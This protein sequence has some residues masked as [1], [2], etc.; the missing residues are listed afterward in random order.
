[1]KTK[2]TWSSGMV[3]CDLCSNTW[4]AVRP[5]GIEKLECPNCENMVNFE[6]VE[7]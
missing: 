4:V 2:E 5:T 3:K 6:E 7:E 1:M